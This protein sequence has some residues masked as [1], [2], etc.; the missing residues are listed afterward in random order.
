MQRVL[1]VG[2]TG[3]FKDAAPDI[4]GPTDWTDSDNVRLR[5]GSV[6]QAGGHMSIYNPPTVVPYHLQPVTIAGA[7]YWIYAGAGKIYCVNGGSH[8]DLTRNPGGDYTAT[9][10]AWTSCVLGGVPIFNAGNTTD[11]PQS[12]DLNIANNFAALAN[13]PASTYCKAMRSY[14]NYLVALNIT[15]PAGALPFTVKWSHPADPGTV[16]TSWDETDPTVEAGE[17]PLSRGQDVIVDGL[18]LRDVFM[19]YKES[20]IWRMRY[21]GGSYV[22]AFE[23]V[24]GQSGALARNCIIELDGVHCVLTGSD[25][26]VHDGNAPTSVLDK[27]ARKHLFASIDPTN[28]QASFLF[29]NP[30]LNEVYV[31][32]PQGGSTVPDKA[33]VWNYK[34]NTIC[35]RDVPS[36][37]H[38]HEGLA[39]QGL[40][41][42]SW[43]S[44]SESWDS[45]VTRWAESDFAPDAVRVVM[46]SANT[47]L[48]LLDAS[49]TFDSTAQSSYIE[50]QGLEFGEPN[51]IK[52]VSR[53]RPNIQGTSGTTVTV[54]VGYANTPYDTPTYVDQTYTIGTTVS[55]DFSTNS[56]RYVAIKFASGTASQ[57]R[58]DSYQIEYEFLGDW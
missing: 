25:L 38:A 28:Y 41:G 34:D 33:L 49:A 21:V 58:L 1:N 46:A 14:R 39:E 12:W 55:C 4:L 30:F 35:F 52:F 17:Q 37:H 22:M 47:K 29:K 32:Y 48:Y 27:K 5:N 9:A 40:T 3:V 26:I 7:R 11:V 8:T 53:I 36:L 44:D 50:R 19:I 13:W 31:C 42:A 16:P 2:A 54:S 20:S 56:G 43:A 24:L 51:K 23:Q 45:D 18:Q 57:W 6:E 10:N 15:K